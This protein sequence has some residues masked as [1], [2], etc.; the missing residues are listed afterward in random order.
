ML[1]KHKIVHVR[2]LPRHS[3]CGGRYER[4]HQTIKTKLRAGIMDALQQGNTN[5]DL[6]ELLKQAVFAYK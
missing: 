5:P 1:K 3:E 4:L 2:S 6:K